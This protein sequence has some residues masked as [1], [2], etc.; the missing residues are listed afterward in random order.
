MVENML[1]GGPHR[2]LSASQVKGDYLKL[3]IIV[4]HSLGDGVKSI[5]KWLYLLMASC[6]AL[7]LQMQPNLVSHLKL[8]WN[9]VL[10]MALLVLGIRFL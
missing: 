5:E 8:V 3:K 1:G 4:A 2:I 6:K 7:F 9:L 10:I